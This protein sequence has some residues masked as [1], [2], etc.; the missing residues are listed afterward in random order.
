[1]DNSFATPVLQQPAKMG[2]DLIVHSGTKFLDGQGRVMADAVCGSIALVDKVMGTFLRSGG[3]NIAPYNA[4]TV[5]K[6]LETL[7]LRVRAQSAAA[8]ELAAWLEAT[9][10]GARV[11]PP[12]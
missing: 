6:G 1:M 8:L 11:L 7:P 5:M 10:G 9:Q 3:L 4:W 12:V 2:A